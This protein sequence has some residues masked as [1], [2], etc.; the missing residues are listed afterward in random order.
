MRTWK[1]PDTDVV[2]AIVHD[3]GQTPKDELR[4]HVAV[5]PT[6]PQ[7]LKQYFRR[8]TMGCGLWLQIDSDDF[9]M[10]KGQPVLE[11]STILRPWLVGREPPTC[12]MCASAGLKPM[13]A[14]NEWFSGMRTRRKFPN[15]EEET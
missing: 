2:H 14:R 11:S 6:I 15:G 13:P 4:Q 8:V 5:A 10:P 1:D 9:I 12:V 7:Y 3:E